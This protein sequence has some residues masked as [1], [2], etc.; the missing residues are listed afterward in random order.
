MFNLQDN[1]LL[2][3]EIGGN[4]EGNFEYAKELTKLAIASE[5]DVVKFQL[6]TG[7]TLVNKKIDSNRNEHFKKFE[8]TK[9]QHIEL[10]KMVIAG[11]K[12]YCAS[13]WDVDM[14]D[15]IDPYISFYKIGSGDLTAYPIIKAIV[16]K[17]KPILLST[18]LATE[19]EVIHCVNYIQCLNGIYKEPEFLSILQC[20]SMYPITNADANLAVMDSFK[21]LFHLPVGYSDHTEGLDALICAVAMGAKILEFHFTDS[22]EGKQFR[23]HKVSLI[24]SE[25]SYLKNRINLI[26]TL[27]GS[28]VKRPIKIEIENGHEKSFRRGVYAKTNISTG[29]IITIDKLV[30]LRPLKGISAVH[31]DEIIGKRARVDISELEPLSFDMFE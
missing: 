26:K 7:D 29:E 6:Y 17:N 2:I 21:S 3:A 23:D 10:A 5:A 12:Q 13:V 9:E 30:C 15:W 18:G 27:K 20:T 4:H 11:G 16:K 1:I 8:L 31:F 22:R 25:I 24:P 19:D 14:L 28:P